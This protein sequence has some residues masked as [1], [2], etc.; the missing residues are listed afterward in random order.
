M[1]YLK[2]FF[3]CLIE[4]IYKLNIIIKEFQTQQKIYIYI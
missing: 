3:S 4:Y 1:I 2:I